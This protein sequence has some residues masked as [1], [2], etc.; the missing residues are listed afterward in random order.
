MKFF[1]IEDYIFFPL[2]KIFRVFSVSLEINIREGA[3]QAAFSYLWI[4]F[5]DQLSDGAEMCKNPSARNVFNP[6]FPTSALC[7]LGQI[8][9]NKT[10]EA[11]FS[12]C[13]FPPRPWTCPFVLVGLRFPSVMQGH[14]GYCEDKYASIHKVLRLY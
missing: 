10:L 5:F 13:D 2:L 8:C 3:V 11:G 12:F 14:W 1:I 7:H 6:S 4:K 9:Q